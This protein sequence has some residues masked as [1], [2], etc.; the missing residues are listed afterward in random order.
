M[1]IV[2]IGYN[3]CHDADL[4]I[5]R[6]NGSGDYLLLLLKTPS[7]FE[8]NGVKVSVDKNCMFIYDIGTPQYYR[9]S[10]STFSNDWVHF[11]FEHDE[12]QKF[13]R[14]NI[15]FNTPIPLGS[16]NE[17]SIIMKS[18]TYEY[19]SNEEHSKEVINGYFKILFYKLSRA[20]N[21]PHRVM[22]TSNYDMLSTIRQKIYTKP[23]EQRTLDSTAHEV[24]MSKSYFQRLYKKYF[25]VSLVEDITRSRME[26]AMSLLSD[27]NLNIN[28]I[29]QLCG[30]NNYAHFERLFKRFVGVS[31]KQYRLAVL[32]RINEELIN[33]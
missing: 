28:S 2:N 25:G 21:H 16:I 22:H 33:R 11:L 26:F 12:L 4:N 23:Y 8:I 18:L 19:C 6:P 7:T 30:Y 1:K 27:T 29:S 17:F 10:Q 32:E 13:L 3:H 5:E 20:I 24:R 9:S 15:P 14:L 31:P